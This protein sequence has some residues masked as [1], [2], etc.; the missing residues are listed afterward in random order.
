MKEQWPYGQVG[1]HSAGEIELDWKGQDESAFWVFRNAFL[2]V[3]NDPVVFPG[4]RSGTYVSLHAPNRRRVGGVIVLP[5]FE[6]KVVLMHVYRHAPRRWEVE[7]PRGFVDEDET[8]EECARRELLEECGVV[9]PNLL[10]LGLMNPDAGMYA[11]DVASY[12][13]ELDALPQQAG[14]DFKSAPLLL[15]PSEVI[16]SVAAGE[17]HDS[18]LTFALVSAIGRS[19]ITL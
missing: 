16:A 8:P 18:F 12:W 9:A 19:L 3:R 7:A 4:G 17:I 10:F 11:Y 2:G 5:V 6:G 15:S 14:E 1:S 13:C